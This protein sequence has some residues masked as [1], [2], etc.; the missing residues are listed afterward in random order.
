MADYGLIL[1]IQ[2]REGGLDD[3]IEQLAEEVVA[4][5]EAGFDAVFLPE[6]HQAHGG[7]VVSPFVV[8]AFLA[9]R[10]TR[11]RFGTAVLA[12][13]LHDPVRLAEDILMLGHATRGRVICG[14]GAAH[15]PPDFALY[16][17]P[18]NKRQQLMDELLDLLE[19]CW[20]NAPFDYQGELHQRKG[21]VTPAP[22]GGTKPPVWIGAH[23]PRGLKRAGERADVW[24]CDPERDIDTVARLAD[25]YR[26]HAE[27]AGRM[28]RVALFRD[29]WVGESRE[30]CEAVWAEHALRVHRLYFNVGVY[31]R[32]FAPWVDEVK[33]REDFDLGRVGPGRFL[34]G[35]GAEVRATS[36]EWC[37]KTGAD[38]V[39]VRLRHPTGPSHAETLTAI[40]RFGR[41]VITP[42]A[43]D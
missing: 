30:E 38:Y 21:H 7:A 18:R 9:A 28:P 13:P 1:P 24:I 17:R 29:G 35:S 22:Y 3:H 43:A 26:A 15:M 2:G 11:I 12:G 19:L 20:S 5:E 16:G 14:M 32:D 10:T 34:Y 37:A 42:A 31:T 23:G 33:S 8:L 25:E 40:A 27:A 6:F 4:A 41:E 36:E 39:A